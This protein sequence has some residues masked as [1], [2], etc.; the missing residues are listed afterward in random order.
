MG[1]GFTLPLGFPLPPIVGHIGMVL[2]GRLRGV[3]WHSM[4]SP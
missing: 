4:I 3:G 1:V 2:V